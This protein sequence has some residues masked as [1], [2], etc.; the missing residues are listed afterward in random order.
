MA[1][2]DQTF[3]QA[4]DLSGRMARAANFALDYWWIWLLASAAIWLALKIRSQHALI[5]MLDERADAAF[6]DVDALLIERHTLIGNLAEIVR[7]FAARVTARFAMTWSASR[8]ASP[9]HA[10]STISPSRN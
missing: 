5:A 3:S 2:A 1:A 9:R 7:A 4:I 8:T 6:G 10:D